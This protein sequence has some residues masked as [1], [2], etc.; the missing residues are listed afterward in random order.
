MPAAGLRIIA[1]ALKGRRLASPDWNGLRP[2][3]DRLRETLFNVLSPRLPGAR[4]LDGFAGTGAVGLEA[5]SRGAAHVTFAEI[6][7]RAVALVTRNVAHCGVENGYAIIRIGLGCGQPMP[8]SVPF[9]IIVLDPPYDTDPRASLIDIV[10]VLAPDGVVVLEHARR[11]DVPA[12]EGLMR[13]RQVTA[14]DSAL[15]F[16]RRDEAT[17]QRAATS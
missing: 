13:V 16:Y 3:S 9:D 4:V 15:T 11:R 1:G 5:L 8:V 2:T 17:A 10:P 6:D 12:A 14:G 7:P